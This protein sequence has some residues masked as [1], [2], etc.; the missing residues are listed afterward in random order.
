MIAHFVYKC[1]EDNILPKKF[2]NLR[3]IVNYLIVE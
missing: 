1:K 2:F 3:K